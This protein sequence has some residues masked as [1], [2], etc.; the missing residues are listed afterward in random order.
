MT[1]HTSAVRT[2]LREDLRLPASLV[3]VVALLVVGA[4]AARLGV[5]DSLG[6][7]QP[8]VLIAAGLSPRQTS[9]QVATVA[10]DAIHAMETQ[11][12]RRLIEPKVRSI[13]AVRGADVPRSFGN[14]N[15]AAYDV[16]WIVKADGTF[17]GLF[18][19]ALVEPTT[20]TNG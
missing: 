10:M 17:V 1:T 6:G 7:S 12:G 16:V 5:F 11:L 4:V 13:E 20:A 19:R 15:F 8:P 14:D 18:G 9:D 3:F 2:R